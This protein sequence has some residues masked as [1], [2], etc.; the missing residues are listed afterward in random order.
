MIRLIHFSD[1]HITSPV[2]GWTKRDWLN[3][4]VAAWMNFR[5]LGRGR[6]FQQADEVLA[7]MVDDAFQRRPDR[8]IFSGDAT[9]LGF[10]SELRRAAEALRIGQEDTPP[11]LAVPGNHDYCT[12]EAAASGLFERY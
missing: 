3:K 11:G 12:R 5:W 6:R 9:A 7:K 4:R 8:L 10:E 1:I 2:L